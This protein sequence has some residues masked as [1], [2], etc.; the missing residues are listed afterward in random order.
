MTNA[1]VETASKNRLVLL[2]APG[3][4]SFFITGDSS[5]SQN[6]KSALPKLLAQGYSIVSVTSSAGQDRTMFAV[7][8]QN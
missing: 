4:E 1:H 7:V 3:G 6:E 2:S 5:Y 8:L